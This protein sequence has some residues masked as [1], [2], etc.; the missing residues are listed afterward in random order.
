MAT[1]S[2]RDLDI[3]LSHKH[4]SGYDHLGESTMSDGWVDYKKSGRNY[5]A[6]SE[7]NQ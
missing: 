1:Y 5:R 6:E 4:C 7:Q 2:Q 3:E